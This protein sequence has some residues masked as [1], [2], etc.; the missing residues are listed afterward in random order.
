MVF[1]V[2][3]F[4]VYEYYE[5][6]FKKVDKIARAKNIDLLEKIYEILLEGNHKRSLEYKK[7]KEER[8]ITSLIWKI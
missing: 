5:N 4:M 1:V 2:K 6:F 8:E 7:R 3:F